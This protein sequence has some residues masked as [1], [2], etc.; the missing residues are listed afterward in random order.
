[1]RHTITP[2]HSQQQP[3]P[4][5]QI[6]TSQNQL[7]FQSIPLSHQALAQQHQQQQH[8]QQALM[9]QQ[10]NRDTSAFASQQIQRMSGQF[11]N[12]QQPY[13][14]G[15]DQT[16]L[17]IQSQNQQLQEPMYLS[18]VQQHQ[19]QQ[20]PQQQL[21]ELP[22]EAM[23]IQLGH[24]APVQ[25]HQQQQR[26]TTPSKQK[27][28]SHYGQRFNPMYPSPESSST[29]PVLSHA[30]LSPLTSSAGISHAS[31]AS[32]LSHSIPA[33]PAASMANRQ[34]LTPQVSPH[35]NAS[36]AA[37]D[38][39]TPAWSPAFAST[40]PS[41]TA[42]MPAYLDNYETPLMVSGPNADL[43]TSNPLTANNL[44]AKS[45]HTPFY[46]MD[47]GMAN[48]AHFGYGPQG[49][50]AMPLLGTA[51]TI[52]PG[53][54]LAQALALSHS[55]LPAFDVKAYTFRKKP[56]HYVAVKHK[57]ALR[58]E[59][60]IYL[61]TS[62][63][64][65][66]RQV[67]RNW[68]YLRFKLDRFRENAQPK[69]KLN[70][71][72]LRGARILDV[73][74]VL[75][76]PNNRDRVIE[77]SCP[78]C[79]MRMDGE[80]RIMQ[81]LAKNFKQSPTGEPL[82]DVRKGHAIVCIKLNCYCDHHN[83]QE[84]F[85]VRMQTSPE[86]V[87]MG[88][89]VKLRIC[90]EARSK[91]GPGEQEAD[92][93]DGLTDIDA[94]V[95]TGSRSPAMAANEQM[96]QSPSL[97]HESTGS[98]LVKGH[99]RTPSTN[100]SSMA[101]PR[102]VDER[103]LHPSA[104]DIMNHRNGAGMNQTDAM[105]RSSVN[106][107]VIAPPKF[108]QIYPL[109]PSEGT[110]MGGTRIT[111]HGAHFDVLQNPVVYFG[112]VAAEL[113]T[114][115]HHDVMECTTPPAE[116]LKPGIVSVQIVS[117]AFPLGAE[118]DSVDF[119]Y[120]APP[121]YDFCNL[122]ATSLSYAMADEY[123]QDNSL[124]FI[125][126]AHGSAAGIGLGLLDDA[127]TFS[128]NDFDVGLSWS[129]TVM[130]DIVLEFLRTIQVL[131]PGRVLPSFKSDS[132]HTLLHLA[133]QS[134]MTRL[135]RELIDMGI[136]HTALDRNNKTALHFARMLENEEITRLLSAAR[137][138]PR[139]MV[140][141][142]RSGSDD[143]LKRQEL[144][145]SLVQ[146][147]EEDLA[148]V[149]KQ[150]RHRKH[151]RLCEMKERALHAMDAKDQAA[152]IAASETAAHHQRQDPPRV[153]VE[154][155]EEDDDIMMEELSNPSSPEGAR[156]LDEDMYSNDEVGEREENDVERKRKAADD[157][158]EGMEGVARKMIKEQAFLSPLDAPKPTSLTSTQ[159][160]YIQNGA[161][162]W[163]K[164]RGASL[165]APSAQLSKNTELRTWICD[166]WLLSS[167]KDSTEEHVS[168]LTG[169]DV[170]HVMAVTATGLHH[171]SEQRSASH[172]TTIR[173]LEHWSLIEMEQVDH[174]AND[175]TDSVVV[176]M[177]GLVA[178][179]GRDLMGERIRLGLSKEDASGFMDAVASAH[180]NL[181]QHLGL[182]PKFAAAAAAAASQ[183]MDSR[184]GKTEH[185]IDSTL[186]L[187]GKVFNVE[188]R[189]LAAVEYTVSED[190]FTLLPAQDGRNIHSI[191]IMA[192]VMRTLCEYDPCLKVRFEGVQVLEDGW[193]RPELIKEL[194]RMAKVMKK[195]DRWNFERCGWSSETA[196]G[197]LSGLKEASEEGHG[198]CRRITL[199]GND[200][201]G[202]DAVGYSLAE[203]LAKWKHL[204]TLDLSDCNIGLGGMA[205]FVVQ[206]ENMY[207]IRLQGNRS[208]HRW[209][210]WVDTLLDKNPELGKCRLGAPVSRPDPELSI[211]SGER[212]S[213][214]QELSVL[215]LSSSPVNQA[216]MA[217]L[218]DFVASN[219]NLRT[220][221]LSRCQLD[222]SRLEA[223]FRTLCIV[224]ETTKFTLDVSHN[225]LFES[226]SSIQKWIEGLTGAGTREDGVPFG[227][228]MQGLIIR[229][230][231]LKKVL[232]PLQHATCFNEFN[233]KGLLIK[234][235]S[236]VAELEGLAYDEACAR[237]RPKDASEET[238]LALGQVLSKNKTL[239][240]LDISGTE[241][242]QQVQE[243][244]GSSPDSNVSSS[245]SSSSSGSG[246]G[247]AS[248]PRRSTGGFGRQ[249]P[250]AF[251]AL[252][253]ND[254]LRVLAM[255]HNRFG[256]D[257][258]QVLAQAL[259]A[260]QGLGVLSCDG[261]DAFTHKAL[262]AFEKVL[263]PYSIQSASS[264]VPRRSLSGPV[265]IMFKGTMED[266]QAAGYNST[267]SIWTPNPEEILMH[268][269]LLS[270]EVERRLAEY[271][272]IETMQAR[273]REQE[274]KFGAGGG[275]AG[276]GATLLSDAKQGY[277]RAVKDR[278]EYLDTYQQIVGA[279][280]E[281]NRRT[282]EVYERKKLMEQGV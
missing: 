147:Y 29:T 187:W 135:V 157:E 101:S 203:C 111:I 154:D 280:E 5:H 212:L 250:L 273:N 174:V 214:L 39:L 193:R 106:G 42:S 139:P 103:V 178:R 134:G 270:M 69:K 169:T 117:S 116:N 277:E 99:Q 256:E 65:E 192:A 120:M 261:N 112:K 196:L 185:W 145:A 54:P 105:G 218:N 53:G 155:T 180:S 245:S 10:H 128:G 84:G 13:S 211:L 44:Y 62:I 35:M 235:E 142:M 26:Q 28:A 224:N 11:F 121:D 161:S 76:S 236:Q 7:Q 21:Q 220:L 136:D 9:S 232:K 191:H 126:N 210:Q 91:S 93:E 215:D 260:N 58:I 171:Y 278:A 184:A 110:V 194:Q 201:G 51:M 71:E 148:K 78:A 168:S 38:I 237:I 125:L 41:S 141:R 276:G 100:S 219:R 233:V 282:K 163:E 144:V 64:D 63:L 66:H 275:R 264:S 130:E 239:V 88:G 248:V 70:A 177:C 102:S 165:F 50:N 43:S 223:M 83:E 246:I 124:A 216:T 160:G 225:L 104:V 249:V 27:S 257:G 92:D 175:S 48:G 122:A 181:M 172:E 162:L 107:R 189:S 95:S 263:P 72:E 241:I 60:I 206:L 267:L 149:V 12:N 170:L 80:R 1:M 109:T 19:Q 67:V 183:S 86:V 140:P 82:I 159:E 97:S 25:Q 272:R 166:S 17:L 30:S 279:V 143:G 90:C 231:V 31:T 167:L 226:E 61:K 251:P 46:H 8:Q 129:L 150:D 262:K 240:M 205:A 16:Q 75:V 127:T 266:A 146:K 186:R 138:P 182:K 202:E 274:A 55:N 259:Q 222:W 96:L 81:V 73:D 199:A 68:D 204:K 188:D 108:R 74:I 89:S 56:R 258:L 77:D 33:D 164:S 190:T 57:N 228:Q 198:P 209:W 123:P 118:T 254:T 37:N 158:I 59:P 217:V 47:M 49:S 2:Q 114:I 22:A 52:T 247:K 20:Q 234:R 238:C 244:E 271:H 197:F 34:A 98:P 243:T 132:G 230:E 195:V 255:D 173:N 176:E 151:Q 156:S 208:D 6:P 281:N 252:G 115:S 207:T 24:R 79:V 229:D 227:V 131:A 87:R 268:K 253:E 85:V 94:P 221:T 153:F 4:L 23:Q 265:K 3:L 213:K 14:T 269:D 32:S 152:L 45:L 119:M 113:V 179:G 200:F 133:T 137:V 15:V 18:V 36:R 40:S 242:E